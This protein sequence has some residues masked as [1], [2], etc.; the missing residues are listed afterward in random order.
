MNVEV[1]AA[2]SSS[3]NYSRKVQCL[4]Y[5]IGQ[6]LVVSLNSLDES[7]MIGRVDEIEQDLLGDDGVRHK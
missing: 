5:C 4:V 7:E 2:L 6:R 1:S 3:V